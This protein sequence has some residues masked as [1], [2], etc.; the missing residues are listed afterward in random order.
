MGSK[1]FK[2]IAVPLVALA[3]T[4]LPAT[5]SAASSGLRNCQPHILYKDYSKNGATGDYAPACNIPTAVVPVAQAHGDGFAWG[6]AAIG[7]GSA[8]V[9]VL[10]G[11]MTTLRVRRRRIAPPTP[12]RPSAA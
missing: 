10:L 2:K 12:A 1:S 9:I 11:G 6:D 8:L 3:L 7:A 5:A 4:G